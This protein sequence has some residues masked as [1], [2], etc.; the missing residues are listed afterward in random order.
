MNSLLR[1]HFIFHI[2]EKTLTVY[3]TPIRKRRKI[4]KMSSMIYFTKMSSMIYFNVDYKTS[5]QQLTDFALACAFYNGFF[6]SYNLQKL[7]YRLNNVA[8]SPLSNLY[9][10]TQH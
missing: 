6:S 5:T 4:A 8:K 1:V 7:A 10:Q 3:N 2:E 9:T